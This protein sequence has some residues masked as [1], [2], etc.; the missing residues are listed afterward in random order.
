[1]QHSPRGSR[2]LTVLVEMQ[3]ETLERVVV[4]PVTP[5][6]SNDFKLT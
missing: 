4:M 3:G 5:D 2:L 6:T 1:M